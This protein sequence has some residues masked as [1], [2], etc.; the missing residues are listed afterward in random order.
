MKT[1]F[2]ALLLLLSIPFILFLMVET[3]YH[4]S[5]GDQFLT[6]LGIETWTGGNLSR[7]GTHS[8]L[9]LIYLP[10]LLVFY[11]LRED[12]VI[13]KLG[14]RRRFAI[15][16]TLACLFLFAQS[17]RVIIMTIKTEANSLQ[18]IS[19]QA[20]SSHYTYD[21]TLK[22]DKVPLY[23]TGRVKLTNHSQYDYHFSLILHNAI[24][25]EDLVLL[26]EDRHPALIRLPGNAT[27]FI[28]LSEYY[29]VPPSPRLDKSD[30]D[31][32]QY[33]GWLKSLSLVSSDG[34]RLLLTHD[35]YLGKLVV[36]KK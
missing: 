32:S 8:S 2:L 24:G 7:L 1:K 19:W 9:F 34:S 23:V 33:S 20:D 13:R 6:F 16:F 29:Y 22:N 3:P 10:L 15:G 12:M 17:S 31:I 27:K 28:D 21:K 35:N 36:P 18:A 14:L 30:E 4:T 11:L 25:G 26:D 5:L